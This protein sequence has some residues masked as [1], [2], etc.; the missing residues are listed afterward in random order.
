[1]GAILCV[2]DVVDQVRLVQKLDTGKIYALKSLDKN[3]MLKRD[4]ASNQKIAR[5]LFPKSYL[6]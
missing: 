6:S 3:E 1:M 4:Q 5:V 2:T